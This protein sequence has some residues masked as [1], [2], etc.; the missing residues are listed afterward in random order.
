M[1]QIVATPVED[2]S[3]HTEKRHQTRLSEVL[4][5]S[6]T[7]SPRSMGFLFLGPTEGRETEKL[8]S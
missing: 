4:N 2:I 3:V 6:L 5:G 7:E 1:A 8:L